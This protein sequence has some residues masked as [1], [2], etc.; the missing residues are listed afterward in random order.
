MDENIFKYMSQKCFMFLHLI[1]KEL[2]KQNIEQW[3][4][5]LAMNQSLSLWKNRHKFQDASNRQSY[6]L[7][8]KWSWHSRTMTLFPKFYIFVSFKIKNV[9]HDAQILILEIENSLA[10]WRENMSLLVIFCDK[11]LSNPFGGIIKWQ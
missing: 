5:S 11:I 6:L 3:I 8:L 10:R 9:L 1:F 4:L 2:K 7:K